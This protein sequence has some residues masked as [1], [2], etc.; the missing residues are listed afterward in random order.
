MT[1]SRL[2]PSV[3]SM[4]VHAAPVAPGP[5]EPSLRRIAIASL[6]T[7][8]LGFGGLTTWA[9]FARLDSAVGANGT[10]VSAGKRKTLTV[11]DPGIIRVVSVREG[12]RVKAGQVL[13]EL[14]DVQAR[15]VHEQARL[16]LWGATA[17]VE[18]LKAEE[19]DS[20]ELAFDADLLREAS[21]DKAIA[22]RVDVE[23][24]LFLSRWDAYE[25]TLRV[26]MQHLAQAREALPGIESQIASLTTRLDLIRTE[27]GHVDALL[28]QGYETRTRMVDVHMT[29][30]DIQG[31]LG[32]ARGQR[33]VATAALEQA[34][35]EV[36]G[37]VANRH[38]DVSKD[39]QD[40]EA[41][42]LD[43]VQGD[44]SS[45]D[46]LERRDIRAPE[47]GVVT[48]MKFFTPG[49]SIGAGQP[50]MDLV[51][52]D[53][54]LLVEVPVAP[55]D[56]ERVRVGQKVNIRLTAYKAHKVPVVT[57]RLV[58]VAADRTMDPQQQP[59][60]LA[61]VA[62][63]PDALKGLDRVSVY[64]GM[65]AD[66]LIIAGERSVLDFLLTPIKENLRH[67]MHEE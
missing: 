11:L 44:R 60:F 30:T 20:R 6:V 38:A 13:M 40:A 65:P 31:Q 21:S 26:A 34:T 42:R 67:G 37:A 63:D 5:R 23:R 17:R 27:M 33:V 41:T 45:S 55:T 64:A 8:V 29:T 51:P 4:V 49:A 58:Y 59:V 2:R 36:A 32:T 61:R 24:R 53:D 52:A 19:A 57:G 54:K 43:A 18:R 50:I 7:L 1:A 62:L 15:A 56:I 12:D 66:V 14:D 16:K 46:L 10:F 9:A 25:G 48:D 35:Q 22:S 47:D 28:K 39:L 3:P